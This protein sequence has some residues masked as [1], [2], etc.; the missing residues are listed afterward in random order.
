MKK[1]K[2]QI[3]TILTSLA[4]IGLPYTC[5]SVTPVVQASH[6]INNY[7]HNNSVMIDVAR[8]HMTKAEISDF[9]DNIDP[10]KFPY[11]QLHLS[12][13]EG[14]AV[15]TN[16]LHQQGWLTK[17]DLKELSRKAAN[18]GITLIP[19]IDV[20]SHAGGIIQDLKNCNS[21]WLDHN[22]VMDNETLDYTNPDAVNFV[23]QLY[24]E[25]LPC[26]SIKD[27]VVIGGDEVPGNVANAASF[28]NFLNKITYYCEDK[29][30]QNVVAWND[31]LNNK[32]QNMLT[33]DLIIASWSPN[34]QRTL[35]RNGYNLKDANSDYCY[36]NTSDLHNDELRQKKADAFAEHD[37]D[38]DLML[39]LWGGD[40]KDISNQDQIDYLNQVQ[41]NDKF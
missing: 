23:K 16:I 22:I 36:Y 35:T 12:D 3:L 5:Q 28:A 27:S 21:P 25:I 18:R 37:Y 40:D 13:N 41:N 29:G 32:V 6:I 20:P 39:C 11:L 15:K 14:F 24:S 10:N 30:Y 34:N 33:H 31:S 17:R 38:H 1:Q 7:D 2:R 9:I 4:L 8:R 19:D 26:F